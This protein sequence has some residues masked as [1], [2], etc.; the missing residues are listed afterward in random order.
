M[1]AHGLDVRFPEVMATLG[2]EQAIAS[3]PRHLQL[4]LKADIRQREFARP[5]RAISRHQRSL[6]LR[7]CIKSM[8]SRSLW[9]VKPD[10]GRS[11][12]GGFHGKEDPVQLW[13]VECGSCTRHCRKM[14]YT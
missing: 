12:R 6:P 9:L 1:E 2:H 5:L 3:R 13:V 11:T 10:G 14:I 4:S 8:R 7:L